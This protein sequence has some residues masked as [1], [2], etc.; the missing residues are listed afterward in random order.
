MEFNFK[1]NSLE[2]LDSWFDYC[3]TRCAFCN[4]DCG[5]DDPCATCR[6]NKL[7]EKKKKEF[8]KEDDK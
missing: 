6:A 4:R 7:Y 1:F 5:K 2:E 3:C 8:G